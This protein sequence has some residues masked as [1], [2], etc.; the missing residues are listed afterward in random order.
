LVRKT[1][2]GKAGFHIR[3]A[4]PSDKEPLMG[5][6]KDVWGG[7]DYIPQVWDQWIADPTAEMF[8]VTKSGRPI[9]MNRVKFLG[10][11]SAWFEGVRVHPDFRGIG[12]ATLLGENSI[13]VALRRGAT[14]FRLTSHVLN[15]EAHRQ[16]ARMQF[17]EIGR[18]SVY[19]PAATRRFRGKPSVRAAGPDDLDSALALLRTSVE[20]G[21]GGPF[22]WDGFSAMTATRKVVAQRL[23]EG[24]VYM[25]EKAVGIKVLA[26]E[27]RSR[28]VEVGLLAGEPEQAVTVA[29]HI[30][31][32]GGKAD[33]RFVTA[34]GASR[35]VTALR[36]DGMS[37]SFSLILYEKTPV[38]S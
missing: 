25:S 18:F 27:G 22:L 35:I 30:F 36:Q 16:I 2:D 34:S 20:P 3:R 15:K 14:V 24:S 7:H 32:T 10:D 37:R 9:A 29:H 21:K 13:E 8:V 11:G 31:A 17:D 12:V 33:W 4:R 23:E 6:I 28:W 38:K 19:S 1:E 5:F 26:G